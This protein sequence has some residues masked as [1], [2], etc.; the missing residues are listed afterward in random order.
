MV[1][2]HASLAKTVIT[3]SNFLHKNPLSLV[4]FGGKWVKRMSKPVIQ[5][6][7]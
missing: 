2:Y 7:K 6:R 1:G 3:G 4:S 5:N